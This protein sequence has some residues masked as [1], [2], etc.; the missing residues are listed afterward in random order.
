[1]NHSQKRNNLTVRKFTTSL[2]VLTITLT[3]QSPA[4]KPEEPKTTIETIPDIETI[5]D[6]G[7]STVIGN[8]YETPWLETTGSVTAILQKDFITFGGADFGD[9][10]KYDPT[11][12]APFNY[13]S[14]DGSFGYAQTGYT[15]YN[16]RG[17]EGNRV[18]ML[19]DGI[20]Q[21]EQYI[22]TTFAQDEGSSGGGGRDYYDPAIFAST[23]ILKGSASSLYGSDALAGVVS[24][25]T[26]TPQDFFTHDDDNFGGLLRTQ[27]FSSNS[28]AA[29]QAFAAFRKDKFAIMLGLA[30]R[31]GKESENNG[32]TPP[33]PLESNSLNLLSKFQWNIDDGNK[34]ELTLEH[35]NRDRTVN[36]LSANQF[37]NIF[38]K[39]I[40]NWENQARARFS[41]NWDHTPTDYNTRFYDSVESNLYYQASQNSSINKSEA[42]TGRI[43]D[44]IIEFDTNIL[45]YSSK[46]LKETQHQQITYGI[47]A[48]SSRSENRFYRE[49]TGLPPY[50]NRISFAPS[51]TIRAASYIQSEF[52]PTSASPWSFILGLR[53]DYYNVQPEL[54]SDYLERITRLSEGATAYNPAEEL[55]NLTIA[56]RFDVKYDLTADSRIYAK[57]SR[58]V[59]NPTAEEISMI[60][61]HPSVDG[62]STGSLTLPNPDLKEESSNAYEIGYKY[63]TDDIKFQA[64][65]FYTKY[66]N[67]IENAT[68]T[69]QQSTDGQDILTTVNRGSATIYGYELSGSVNLAR[70]HDHLDC[71]EIGLS[72]GKTWGINNDDNT[73]INSIEPWK[74]VAWLGYTSMNEKFSS[75]LSATYVDSVKRVNDDD[76]GPYFRPPSYFTIDLSASYQINESLSVQ[77]GIN[78]LFDE[79][80]WQWSNSR[81]SGGHIQNADSVDDRSTAPGTNGFLSIEYSF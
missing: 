31:E 70:F 68:P 53:L 5:V 26:P 6:L 28:S 72:T 19:L 58:G 57:Y 45:G 43:R 44:Q 77:A 63:L 22:S 47:E 10:V 75:R 17:V 78:N 16:I 27:Q 20:R 65:S 2:S 37:Q 15:G 79:Q 80:Y 76:G 51:D 25:K 49:D 24:F 46:F 67:F 74:S 62:S 52:R 4:Q 73:W 12:T 56:P 3:S 32:N 33:N 21:P 41:L 1:M 39:A 50:P 81:R 69:G 38:D 30:Y 18:S 54:S 48:S 36:A 55:N 40:I 8:S 61:D 29:T 64:S 59:R 11:V 42:L 60:F 14:A 35:F 7:E 71:F 34:V 13:G 66:S 23:E 9:L